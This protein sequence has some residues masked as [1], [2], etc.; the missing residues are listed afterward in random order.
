[1]WVLRARPLAFGLVLGFGGS[2]ERRLIA[3]ADTLGDVIREVR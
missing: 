2:D 3:A 1:L